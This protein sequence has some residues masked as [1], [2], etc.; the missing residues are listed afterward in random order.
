[1][2]RTTIARI[3]GSSRRSDRTGL[4]AVRQHDEGGLA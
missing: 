2:I 1:M 3:A 4:D